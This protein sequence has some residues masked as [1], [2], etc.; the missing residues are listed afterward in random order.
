MLSTGSTSAASWSPPRASWPWSTS[1]T[2]PP[3][4]PSPRPYDARITYDADAG[5]VWMAGG[6]DRGETEVARVTVGDADLSVDGSW[7]AAGWLV[8]A[9]RTG[10]RLHVVAVAGFFG[11]EGDAIPFEEGPVPCDEVLHPVVPSGPEATLVVTLPATGDVAP[12]N[13]AEIVG[14]GQF[15]HVTGDAVVPRHADLGRAD[16]LDEHPSL[17]PRDVDPHGLRPGR[18]HAPQPVLDVRARRIPSGRR[19]PPGRSPVHRRRRDGRSEPAN[20][21]DPGRRPGRRRQR[22]RAVER[23][24]GPRHRRRSRRGRPDQRFGH[25]GETL[26]GIRFDGEVAY[27][28]TFLQTDPFYVVDVADPGA[29]QVVGEVELPGFSAYLHPIGDGLVAGFGPGEDGR[30]AVKL[31]DVSDPSPAVVADDEV[32]GDESP[33]AWD[34]HAFLGLGDGRFAVP[35]NTWRSVDP[36]GCTEALAQ[37]ADVRGQGHRGRAVRHDSRRRPIAPNCSAAG[38]TRSGAIRASRRPTSPTRPWS[39]RGPPAVPSTSSSASRSRPTRRAP[40]S[41][42]WMVAGSCWPARTWWQSTRRRGDLRPGVHLS[43]LMQARRAPV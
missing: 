10:D 20:G 6:N 39:S 34:H 29:P 35:A 5:I 18:W 8:D 37:P 27:A 17:R 21:P 11:V 14:S 16:A 31:F 13:A 3:W 22:R 26:Q 15:V 36:P 25:A 7:S 32:I 33:V 42:T 12:V 30:A 23:D 19:H 9:R 4:P 38:W 41:L 2:G 43:P 24:R 28:V 1:S 40:E